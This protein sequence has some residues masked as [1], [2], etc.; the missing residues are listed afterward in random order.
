MNTCESFFHDVSSSFYQNGS[1]IQIVITTLL[2]SLIIDFHTHSGWYLFKH[3]NQ[4]RFKMTVKWLMSIKRWLGW[5]W[6]FQNEKGWCEA[7]AFDQQDITCLETVH[8][9]RF[10]F[11][12]TFI[13][14]MI[15]KVEQFL[16]LE[17]L[18][19][20][21]SV[22]GRCTDDQ[23]LWIFLTRAPFCHFPPKNNRGVHRL[24]HGWSKF[25][26][27]L[28]E[29][30]KFCSSVHQRARPYKFVGSILAEFSLCV[31]FKS[32][33]ISKRS[34]KFSKHVIIGIW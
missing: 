28:G 16:D 13:D 11:G 4:I 8:T 15:V 31:T 3:S 7:S 25:S 21:P 6:D 27:N 19:S 20:V 23:I 12:N 17:I 10:V 18:G 34:K 2:K 30:L 1:Y 9:T 26:L 29:N 5:Q 33:N 14:I 22:H 32:I 24:V